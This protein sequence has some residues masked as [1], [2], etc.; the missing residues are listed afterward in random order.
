MSGT[1]DH[2]NAQD[3]HADGHDAHE[4]PIK[5]PKQLIVAV[6]FAFGEECRLMLAAGIDQ[7]TRSRFENAAQAELSEP[8]ASVFA[9]GWR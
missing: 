8:L 3:T 4:G 9:V 2:A 1:Q 7:E 5:T 6:F